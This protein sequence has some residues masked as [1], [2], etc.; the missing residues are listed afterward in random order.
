MIEAVYRLSSFGGA[1]LPQ[2]VRSR[3]GRA[4]IHQ[5]Q[6][7]IVGESVPDRAAAL[8]LRVAMRIPGLRGRLEFRI[9]ERLP[10]GRRHRVEPPF[11]GAGLQIVGGDIAAHAAVPHV[12]TA[13]ADDDDVAGDLRRA[14]AGVRQLVVGDGVDHPDLLA[15]R[16]IQCVQTAVDRRDVH[17]ALPNRDAAVDQVAARISRGREIVRLG[18]VAPQ[19]AAGR[20]IDRVHVTPGA[21]GIQDA[22][23]DDRRRL[24]AA[25]R[26]S[27]IVVP[28]EAQVLDVAGIDELQGRVIAAVLVAPA[29]EPVLRFRIGRTAGARRR[30]RPAPGAAPDANAAS[31]ASSRR[32]RGQRGRC[33]PRHGLE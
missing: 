11:E 2:I 6:R 21:R 16:R 5:V 7:A 18:I 9:L 13:V 23:D 27:E 19:F 3:I 28:G 8:V 1:E 30:R 25:L 29:G 15:G 31:D 33:A 32:I 4:E 22:V 20:R 26:G 10:D 17:L 24:L 14:G 12:R